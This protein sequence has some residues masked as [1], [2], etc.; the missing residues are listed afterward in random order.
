MD[1][2][3]KRREVDNH[4]LEDIAGSVFSILAAVKL[5]IYDLLSVKFV[6]TQNKI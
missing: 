1:H 2:D 6:E 3:N 4:D 5:V